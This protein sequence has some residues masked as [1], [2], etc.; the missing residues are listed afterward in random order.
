MGLIVS[1]YRQAETAYSR[2]WPN[3]ATNGGISSLYPRLC[4]MNVSGPFDPDDETA[5][6]VLVKGQGN[7]VILVPAYQD[8]FGVWTA[9]PRDTKDHCGPM[10]GGNYASTSD[11]RWGDA[12]RAL[13]GKSHSAIA[14]HDRF[15]T[16]AAYESLSR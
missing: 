1:V 12:V 10:F 14:I 8:E 3:D 13:G 11:S 4:V 16:W 9:A 7:T 2:Q 6:V 15:E 5:P